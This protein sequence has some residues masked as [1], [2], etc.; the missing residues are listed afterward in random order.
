MSLLHGKQIKTCLEN[1]A[2]SN[3]TGRLSLKVHSEHS[4]LRGAGANTS[5]NILLKLP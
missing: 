1:L 5:V 2:T 3:G 4:M